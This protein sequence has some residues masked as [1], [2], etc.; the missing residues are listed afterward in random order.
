MANTKHP[1]ILIVLTI[2]TFLTL[3]SLIFRSGFYGWLSNPESVDGQLFNGVWYEKS[4][5]GS[6]KREI[7]VT[8][9]S[10]I[11]WAFWPAQYNDDHPS[12]DLR[13][14]RA[15]IPATDEKMWY[16]ILKTLDAGH[17][18][19]TAIVI[20]TTSYKVDTWSVD[21]ENERLSISMLA[22]I[23][24]ISSWFELI[25]SFS[26]RELRKD[27]IL[28]MVF[29][30]NI[31]SADIQNL[32]AHPIDR[33]KL[34]YKRKSAGTHW[35][36]SWSGGQ[37]TMEDLIV[38]PGSGKIINFPSNLDYFAR[39]ET[40]REFV[41]PSQQDALLFTARNAAYQARWLNKIVDMY[42]G[43][44]TQLIFLQTPCCPFPL[45]ARGPIASAPDLRT[46]LKISTNVK[47]IDQDAFSALEHPRY[48]F[49]A[50]H[51]NTSG[52]Q[53]FTNELGDRVA[54]V[55]KD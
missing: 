44:R 20:P 14:I 26:Y 51:L 34:L 37:G 52:R 24:S 43:S 55:L 46:L 18:K 33:L 35:L 12:S 54:A 42:K 32:I 7:L 13:F 3:D 6:G 50:I 38:D 25:D 45:P 17:D 1:L 8:G 15:A 30:G 10:R 19:Y 9:N 11:D 41:R 36:D 21:Q 22:P 48:F 47:F 49:D 27:A 39:Q 16:F 28:S 5:T 2:F 40:I 4:R 31:Y 53:I 23:L 29:A